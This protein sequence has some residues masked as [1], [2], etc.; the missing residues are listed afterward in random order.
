MKRFVLVLAA[1]A[2]LLP[3]VGWAR[4]APGRRGLIWCEFLAGRATPSVLIGRRHPVC[5]RTTGPAASF[6]GPAQN[7]L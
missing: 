6:A 2:P 3:G 5:G 4:D 7:L 1:L